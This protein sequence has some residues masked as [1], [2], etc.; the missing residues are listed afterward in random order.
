M[1]VNHIAS[2]SSGFDSLYLH[3]YRYV[4]Q[5]LECLPLKQGDV[6][7]NLIMPIYVS[8]ACGERLVCKTNRVG[9]TPTRYFYFCIF[10]NF[11]L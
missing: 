5:W 6:S 10:L 11:L 2:A 8:Y 3:L 9:S 1:T 4:A 7:S